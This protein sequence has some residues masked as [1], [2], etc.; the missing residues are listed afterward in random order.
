MNLSKS[1]LAIIFSLVS[2]ALTAQEGI[3]RGSVIDETGEMMIMVTVAAEGTTTGAFTDLDG[4]FNLAIAPGTYSLN[5]S[6]VGY[7]GFSIKDVIVKEGEVT[8]LESIVLK[9]STVALDEV[10]VTASMRKSTENALMSLK[11]RSATVMDGISAVSFKKMGDSD[12]ASSMKR[13]TGVSVEGGKYVY[14]R[15]L[16]DRYTKTILNGVDIPGLDPD[17][18]TMQLDIFPTSIIDNIMV[19]KSFNANMPADFTGGVVDI[20][21]KDFPEQKKGSIFLGSGYNPDYH[22]NN[23]FLAYKGG[24][25][26]F[27]GFD[28]G[29]RAIPAT[30]NLP[31]FVDAISDPDGEAGTRFREVLDGFNPSMGAIRQRNLMDYNFGASFGNQVPFKKV[32]LG[33]N[34]GLTYKAST[35]YYRNAEYGRYGLSSDPDLTE[36]EVREFQI[37]DYGS[38]SVLVSGLAGFALK[39]T[40]SKFRINMIH[41]Q[42]GVSRA[43]IFDFEGSDQGSVFSA[44][45]HNLEYNQRSLS[46][47]LVDGKHSFNNAGLDIVWKISPTL[48]K[49]SDPDARFVRYVVDNNNYE[50]NTEGGFPERIWRDLSEKNL[51]GV[52]HITKK[53]KFRGEDARLHFGGTYTLKERDFVIRKF[54]LNIRNLTLTGNP[55]ELFQPE[56]IWPFNGSNYTSGTTY[57]AHFVPNNPNQY[58]SSATNAAGYISTEFNLLKNIKTILG[59]RVEKYTQYYTGQDQI[60]L[61]ILDNDKVIDNLD[62]FPSVNLVFALA[63][64][65][66]LRLAYARTTARPSFK[67]MSFAEIA[68]PISGRTFVGGMFRDADDVKGVEYWNGNLRS[69]YIHNYDLRWERFHGLGQI[70]SVSAYYKKFI[71]PIEIVQ[72]ASVTGSFQP[73]NVGNGE[74]LGLE[75]E[76]RHNLKSFSE[77]L[78]NFSVLANLSFTKSK[79]AL[80]AT[81]YYSRQENARTGE[82]VDRERVMAGQAPLLINAGASYDGGEHGFWDGFEAGLYY[83]VQGTTLQYVG[84]ADRPDIYMLPFHSLNMTASKKFG[85]DDKLKLG[86]KVDNMLNDKKESV[87]KSFNPTDQFFTRLEPGITFHLKLTYSIF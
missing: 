41:M 19:Y 47:I 71:D 78:S 82:T 37:G 8:L 79:I 63:S 66:N 24:K 40:R 67:E 25:T 29:S 7:E 77:I 75:F 85:S 34:F 81:E 42:N 1:F 27:L 65:Q 80:S 4:K 76:A 44:V 69:S 64:D 56:N 35:E 53:Y 60:G 31:F 22:F 17:R 62:L 23:D 21:I 51:S 15:G 30:N 13:V 68:D 32:T 9:P 18:N 74:V 6:F 26:D 73:R 50:I 10:T 3:I 45:Q 28:D 48:S 12:A 84:I 46:N 58:N 61:N 83:N 54:A 70:I 52:L 87:F 16:G 49:I 20:S 72:Y 33:Y 55:E 14:V 43:G 86:F 5:L 11:M 57:E 36:M 59:V 38:S 39:T 2:L